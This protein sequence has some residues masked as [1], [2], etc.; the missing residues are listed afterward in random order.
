MIKNYKKNLNV[1]EKNYVYSKS[2][3][4]DACG[5]GLVASTDGKK[6]RKIVE[7]GIEAL[8]AVWHRGAVDADGKTGDGAGIHVEIPYDF[9]EEKI[10]TK[11]HKHDNSEICVGMIFLPR[12]NFNVQEDAKTIVEK[13]LTKSNFKIYGWRQVPIN[14]KVLGDK[15]NSNRPEI[16]QILFK[17]NDKNLVDKDLERKLYEIRRKIENEII[18]SNIEGFYICSLSS[19]SIIYKGMFLAEA[20]SDFYPDLNDKRFISRYA[21]FHQRFSTNTFPSWDLAQPFR[22][23]AHN[24][25]INTFRGNCNWMKVHEDEM[26]SKLFEN[27]ENLKPVIQPGASDSAALDNVFELLNISGQS[28][29]L[30]KLM[31]IPDAWSKKSKILSKDHQRLFNFLN[32]TMEPWDGPA[33]I[34]A[35]DN[36][37]AI[38]AND[39][40]GLRPLR[41]TITKDKLLFA[42]SET[43]MIELDEKKIISKGRLGP[44]EII[45]I[46]I[47]KGKVFN[48][49]EIKN[50][51]AKEFKHFNSQIVDLDKKIKINKE[52]FIFSG[53]DLRKRQHAFGI[54][55]EDLEMILHPMVEYAKEAVGSMGDDT[56]LAVLSDRYRPLYH[57]FRQNFSQ[58]TNPPIDSLRENKVMSL[59]TRFGNLGNILDFDKLTKDNIYVLESPILSNSQFE[60]FTKFF[61][62]KSKIIDCTF[63]KDN[64]LVES[65]EKILKESEIAV[66]QGTTQLILTD[67]NISEEK[68]AIPMLLCVGA[69]NKYLIEKKLRGYVSINVQTG[70][71][72]DTHSFATIIGVGAT[73][74]NPYLALDSLYQRYEKKL[75]GKLN[76]EECIERYIKSI[77]FGLLKIMSKMGISVLSSYRGGCNFE[78]LGLSRT[79]VSEYFHGITSK[80]SGIGLVGIEE[81]IKDIHKE[82]FQGNDNVLPIGGIYKYRKNGEVHQYQGKLIHLLQSAVTNNS[83]DTYKKYTKGIYGL[84]PINIRDLID[85]RK[86]YLKSSINISEVEPT[87]EILKRFGSGSM[88]H[89]ALSKEAHET[90]A[91]GMNR[92]K[93]ASCS[94]EGGEDEKRFALLKN[95]DSANSRV[96]QIASARFGVTI[97]YLNNCNEIEIK[98]SQG[99][100]PGEGGQLPGFKVTDEIAKLRHSTPGV[101]LISPPPHHDIYSIEDLAQLIYDL[102][103]VNPK[104]RVAVKLVASS[105]IG[106]IAA[107]VAKAK[108]DIILISGHNGGTGATPQTSVKYVGIPWEMGLTEV[109]QVLILNNLRHSV[110]LKTDGGIKTGRD[111]VIAAMM[112]AEEYGVATTALVAMG[113]IMVRQC[114]SNTCPVGVCTQDEKLREKFNG[115]PEKVVNLFNFIAEEVREILADLGFKTLNDIIGRTDLLKQVSTGSSNLDDLDLHPLFILPD[116]GS[117]KRYCEKKDINEI[118]DTLDQQILPK[119][120]DK[121]GIKKVIENEF[122]IKNIHRAVGTR[123]SYHLLQKYGHDKLEKDFLTLK[124]KGSAGQSFGAFGIKG[125]KLILEGD[126]NDYVA[127]GL[128]GASISIKLAKESNLISNQNTIIGNTVL[129]GATSGELFAS[130]K[131]GERFAVRNSGATTVIEGCDSNGCEYMTGGNVVILGEVGD[132]FAAGMTGG[133]AFIFDEKN[134]FEKKVNPETV[135]WQ[136]VETEYWKNLLKNLVQKHFEETNS[137]IAKK[138]ISNYKNEINYF[139]QVCP[140]E[141]L[142]KL[143]NPITIKDKIKVAI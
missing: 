63:S 124:F 8:K 56:P 113:C 45:G 105:G 140:K 143:D 46:R 10:E 48:N 23:I 19:K 133:M 119:I 6:L 59:K 51:L 114:H 126:A 84:P 108:A 73:T 41:Y 29:P 52:K 103:Q 102:K 112:G 98:I 71:A 55:I 36:E 100:K 68:I 120:E 131:A 30:A 128:S 95:N 127:K 99:A 2:M 28:A 62:K 88:S 18:K 97:N 110:T 85:F 57:F 54:S 107:G 138:I 5:V 83:Y 64:S 67:I 11:G 117:H 76:Y 79:I 14:T 3:E 43:G 134:E 111:V 86:R 129:Y 42:G 123:I 65:L 136:R 125:L 38:V 70:E 135:I 82:A 47:N 96:K 118:P 61:G 9:F 35:T 77:N 53:S 91:I 15:A 13:E 93:G 22:A 74:I 80:I 26:E 32:S 87:T 104:A 121:I 122:I 94:G 12:D 31:L 39:R 66:R 20:L 92:I 44:G 21:I 75:F 16:T 17:H 106:T 50:Y 69:I 58:V 34:A 4:H 60:K 24:G 89:G 27:I 142:D 90:L 141:M 81:K 132:N 78:A 49:S 7:Y 37:W 116:P 115:T 130:G 25:E 139:Y 101:T 137:K 72:L 33:A 1:L 40:N 109:N